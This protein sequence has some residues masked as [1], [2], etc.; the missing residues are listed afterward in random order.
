MA[1]LR[2]VFIFFV[3]LLCAA[4]AATLAYLNPG[5]IDVNLAFAEI[6]SVP[7]PVA[8]AVTFA[9]GWLFGLACLASALMKSMN[10]RR[11][12]RRDLR[13]AE[14]EISGLRTLPLSDAN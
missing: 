6:K 7:K 3:I 9:F 5:E 1:T 14:S 12:L 11:R 13:A 8:F 4:A 2:K 10:Q